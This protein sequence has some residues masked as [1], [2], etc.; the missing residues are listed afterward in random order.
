MFE[1]AARAYM[2]GQIFVREIEL[3]STERALQDTPRSVPFI[4]QPFG[5]AVNAFVAREI[6]DPETFYSDLDG[7]R[8]R[9]FTASNLAAGTIRVRAQRLLG[10][11]LTDGLT[12]KEFA[13][14]IRSA[15]T[16]LGIEPSSHGYLR[17]VFDTNVATNYGAGRMR[18][19]TDP[20]VSRRR[21]FVEYRAILDSRNRESHRALHGTI[22]RIDSEAWRNIAP[23]NGYNC[24]CSMVTR[25]RSQVDLSKVLAEPPPGIVDGLDRNFLE[26]PATTPAS[27]PG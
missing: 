5:E 14:Q 12:R 25:K 9:S 21:P 13:D 15:E 6:V 4:E 24:R 19:I 18:Q 7:I 20:A 17:T 27:T 26:P 2:A 3:A 22:Y 1:S 10:Q 11:A 8:Q 23:P 16:S